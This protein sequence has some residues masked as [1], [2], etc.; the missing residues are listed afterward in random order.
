MENTILSYGDVLFN[1]IN[2]AYPET[3]EENPKALTLCSRNLKDDLAVAIQIE[4]DLD[5][6]NAQAYAEMAYIISEQDN[7]YDAVKLIKTSK[8]YIS[9]VQ[10]VRVG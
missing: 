1:Y 2:G 8:K 4:E 3:L 5:K 10:K 6:Y 9:I 7:D